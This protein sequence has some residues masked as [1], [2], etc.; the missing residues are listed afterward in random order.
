[1]RWG[2]CSITH[3]NIRIMYIML[4]H[5]SNAEDKSSLLSLLTKK[6]KNPD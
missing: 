1:M 5:V 6:E 4:N 2:D 3:Y